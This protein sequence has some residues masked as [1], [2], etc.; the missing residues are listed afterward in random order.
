MICISIG[1]LSGCKSIDPQSSDNESNQALFFWQDNLEQRLI[2]LDNREEALIMRE[3]A[4][5]ARESELVTLFSELLTQKKALEDQQAQQNRQDQV[6]RTP[7]PQAASQT[8]K[9]VK[10]NPRTSSNT[11]LKNPNSL[12]KRTVLG[13][14]EYIY[15]D[16]PGISLSARIDTGA[17]TSSL[18]ALD[19]IEFERDGKPY[20][21]FNIIDPETEE[22]IE[23]I[24][25]IRGY[26]KIKK[27][28]TESQ[29]RPIVRLRVILG[30]LDELIS[31]TLV[32]RSKFK[33]QILMGRNFLR[34]LA[35]VDVSKEYT[36]P[37]AKP[38]TQ[39]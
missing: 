12:D 6:T 19:M 30:D 22:K 18:N 11:P 37:K 32:D 21:R 4:I 20:I 17:Q 33:Q 26:T 5:S 39:Q 1:I 25:R 24:R 29:R 10:P 3:A 36:L 7:T 31:F 34:D 2:A 8:T 13:G 14:L 9:P 28:K 35:I 15:L 38:G 23:L 27:H 16:P